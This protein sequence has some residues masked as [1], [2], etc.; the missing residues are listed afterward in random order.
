VPKKGEILKRYVSESAKGWKKALNSISWN[1]NATKYDIRE[2]APDHEKMGKGITL[3]ENEFN[4][5]KGSIN[6]I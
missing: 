3:S 5:L 1:G 4:A 2:R 6:Q